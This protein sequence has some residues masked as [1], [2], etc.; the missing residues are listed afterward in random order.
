MTTAQPLSERVASDVLAVQC[1]LESG[2]PHEDVGVWQRV[3]EERLMALVHEV[4]GEQDPVSVLRAI[5]TIDHRLDSE[6]VRT[7]EDV[8]RIVSAVLAEQ[9]LA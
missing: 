9:H 5:D 3:R 4:A 1:V 8:L 6:D 7:S 2:V